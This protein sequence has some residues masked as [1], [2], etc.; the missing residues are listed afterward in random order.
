MKCR[1]RWLDAIAATGEILSSRIVAAALTS[2]GLLATWID[3]R[4]AVVT[5]GEH[6]VGGAALS[7]N[8]RRR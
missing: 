5:D 1:P 6:T 7:R 2:H 4:R 3:A 8:H